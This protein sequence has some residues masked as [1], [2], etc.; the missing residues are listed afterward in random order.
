MNYPNHLILP[1]LNSEP[2]DRIFDP[3]N[4]INC[5][6]VSALYHCCVGPNLITNKALRYRAL[7]DH[8]TGMALVFHKIK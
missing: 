4:P 6:D 3:N 2:I 7:G 1:V 8:I 5:W